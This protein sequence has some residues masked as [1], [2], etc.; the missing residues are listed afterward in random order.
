MESLSRCIIHHLPRSSRPKHDR[1][2]WGA[3][4]IEVHNKASQIVLSLE[5]NIASLQES[6]WFWIRLQN[7][8][9]YPPR[10]LSGRTV[11][12]LELKG[13]A[14]GCSL[15]LSVTLLLPYY[16]PGSTA[17]SPNCA[18][19]LYPSTHLHSA[20]RVAPLALALA[21]SLPALALALYHRL[22]FHLFSA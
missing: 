16:I 21:Q 8:K 4:R 19:V 18:C 10:K 5:L 7:A 3:A 12:R 1:S 2:G 20:H 15:Y 9:Q 22:L 13:K 6:K 17:T 11:E 14:G